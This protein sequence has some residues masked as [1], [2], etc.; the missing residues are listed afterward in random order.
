M[1]DGC[2]TILDHQPQASALT[3]D[4]H[5]PLGLGLAHS[6]KTSIGSSIWLFLIR[7]TSRS[8]ISSC[9]T[10]FPGESLK[11]PGDQGGNISRRKFL[12]SAA[13]TTFKKCAKRIF[14]WRSSKACKKLS[15]NIFGTAR[16]RTRAFDRTWIGGKAILGSKQIFGTW[17][18]PICHGNWPKVWPWVARSPWKAFSRWAATSINKPFRLIHF[19]P[20]LNWWETRS[21]VFIGL[22][23]FLSL[24]LIT[25]V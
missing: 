23:V 9:M 19:S 8:K 22:M 17:Q 14:F 6:V 2:K 16:T 1:F 10:A 13:G 7:G 18:P 15:T 4:R 11:I 20:T 5:A 24:E 21:G 3:P 12:I 25:L